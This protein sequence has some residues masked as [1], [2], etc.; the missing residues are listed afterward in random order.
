ME[1][2]RGDGI[3]SSLADTAREPKTERVQKLE[4]EDLFVQFAALGIGLAV[5]LIAFLVERLVFSVCP[6]C[7]KVLSGLDQIF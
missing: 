3:S 2:L 5:T 7:S 6:R 1:K 4:L